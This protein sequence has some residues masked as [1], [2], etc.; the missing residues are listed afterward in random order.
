MAAQVQGLQG[1]AEVDPE[2]GGVA[3]DDE[4]GGEEAW[5]TIKKWVHGKSGTY[6]GKGAAKVALLEDL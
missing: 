3:H 2:G 1:P 4:E 5:P 6:S